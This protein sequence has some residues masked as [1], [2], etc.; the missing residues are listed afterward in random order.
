MRIFRQFRALVRLSLI[1]QWRR[2]E[3]FVL[4]LLSLA[5]MLPL[6]LS[7]PFGDS[8]AS[9]Y[10]DEVA[11]L[12]IWVFSFFIALGTGSRL[13][14]PEFDSRTIY[15]LLAKPISRTR[16]LLGKFLGA[17]VSVYLALA[18][19]YALFLA[20]VLWRGGA[21]TVEFAQAFV[22]H[23]A[24]GALAVALSI[25]FSL[26]FSRGAAL[27]LSSM[28]IVGMFL[29]GRRLLQYCQGVSPVVSWPLK[30][31]YAVFPHAEFFDMRQRMVHVWGAVDWWVFAAVLGYALLYVLV[32]LGLSALM[33]KRKRL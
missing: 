5:V 2:H 16:L 1:E 3:L 27:T 29:F 18:I 33:L 10:L 9:R 4:V 11:L 32:L 12:L 26:A 15:P 30:V 20:S 19:F 8:G 23:C 21:F 28:T 6:S 31:V 25:F 7:S 17:V 24:F 13:F 22:L 14:P